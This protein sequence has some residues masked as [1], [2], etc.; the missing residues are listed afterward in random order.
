MPMMITMLMLMLMMIL[1]MKREPLHLTEGI[2][3]SQRLSGIIQHAC[4]ANET[5][6]LKTKGNE[7][8]K[9]EEK[10]KSLAMPAEMV[11]KTA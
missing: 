2:Y 9:M 11:V 5:E 4:D 7:N 8:E 6:L 3:F 10:I 1:T